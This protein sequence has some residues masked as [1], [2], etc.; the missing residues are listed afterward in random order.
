M[1]L[2]DHVGP[3]DRAG[4]LGILRSLAST[5]R[6]TLNLSLLSQAERESCKGLFQKL[7][8]MGVPRSMKEGLSW[9]EQGLEEQSGGL[10]EEERLLRELLELYQVD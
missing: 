3:A 1:A 6:F 7:Q 8:A 4:V 2:A 5:G 10:Q 9:E